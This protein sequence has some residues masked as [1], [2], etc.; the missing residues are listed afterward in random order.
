MAMLNNQRVSYIIPWHVLH[1]FLSSHDMFDQ[2]VSGLF[3]P[4]DHVEHL[5]LL[6][7]LWQAGKTGQRW[8]P[9][10]KPGHLGFPNMGGP[11]VRKNIEFYRWIFQSKPSSFGH[12]HLWKTHTSA[13]VYIS[14]TFP[15]RGMLLKVFCFARKFDFGWFWDWMILRCLRAAFFSDRNLH[16]ECSGAQWQ[17]GIQAADL[18]T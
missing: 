18:W 8:S 1:I 16:A 7:W 6:R 15:S 12:P 10:S 3:R 4:G 5:L 9:G 11:P 2:A 17:P 14:H 13:W